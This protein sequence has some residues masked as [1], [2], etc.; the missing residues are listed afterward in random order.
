MEVVKAATTF[1]LA[2][3][4]LGMS[5]VHTYKAFGWALNAYSDYEAVLNP[6]TVTLVV[7]DGSI[8]KPR[9]GGCGCSLHCTLPEDG[10][11]EE[12]SDGHSTTSGTSSD[13]DSTVDI[14]DYVEPTDE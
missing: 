12:D 1:V 6:P 3:A 8:D 10:R 14:G 9:S 7:C 2:S 13:T 4:A 5:L 11:L